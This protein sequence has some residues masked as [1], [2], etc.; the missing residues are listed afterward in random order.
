ML[1]PSLFVFPPIKG[2]GGVVEAEEG[3]KGGRE[4]GQ[5]QGPGP[6]V[7][8]GSGPWSRREAGQG[9]TLNATA[10]WLSRQWGGP[11]PVC[12]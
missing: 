3:Y 12:A 2:G 11:R 9:H 4:P 1:V 10:Q 5:G 6:Q 8:T 7:W